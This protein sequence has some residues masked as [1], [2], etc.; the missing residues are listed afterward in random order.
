VSGGVN[1]TDAQQISNYLNRATYWG[2]VSGT[3]RTKGFYGTDSAAIETKA[4]GFAGDVSGENGVMAVFFAD[5][6]YNWRSGAQR[7]FINFTDESTQP[8]YN[9]YWKTELLC[10]KIGGKATVHTVYSGYADTSYGLNGAWGTYDERP[11]EMSYCTGGT[12]KFVP[13]DASDLDLS[14]LP[15]AGALSNSYLVEYVAGTQG[16]THSVIIT[17]KESTADGRRTYTVEY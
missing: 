1:F 14:N 9:L 16:T 4:N 7:V 11:W 12:T 8:G 3:S 17:I 15:V 6:N 2:T 5:S 13:Q 10:E